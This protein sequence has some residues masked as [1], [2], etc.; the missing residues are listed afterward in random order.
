ML[1]K[2]E[3]VDLPVNAFKHA[4]AAGTRQVGLWCTLSNGYAAEVVAGSGFDWLLF[5]TE[6][7]PN[8]I[9]TVLTGLQPA[10]RE[11]VWRTLQQEG[12]LD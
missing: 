8:E 4:I 1:R 11:A 2:G 5:D 3:T 12:C 7:S 9:D 6:H 10:G